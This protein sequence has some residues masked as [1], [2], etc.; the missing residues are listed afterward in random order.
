MGL[1]ARFRRRTAAR[2][3]QLALA[4]IFCSITVA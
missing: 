1:K 3:G 4:P 2:R